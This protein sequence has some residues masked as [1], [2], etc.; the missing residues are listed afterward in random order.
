MATAH[1]SKQDQEAVAKWL[2]DHWAVHLCPICGQN[3]WRAMP[4]R[5]D[6]DCIPVVCGACGYTALL[7][8]A[9]LGAV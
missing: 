4:H 3:A 8:P 1:L 5:T 7:D 9:V 6:F 2:Q